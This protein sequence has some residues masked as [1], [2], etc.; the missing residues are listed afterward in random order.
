M[1][2]EQITELDFPSLF[3]YDQRDILQACKQFLNG[4]MSRADFEALVI[5]RNRTLS[6]EDEKQ[7]E[8]Y[9]SGGM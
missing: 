3:L 5:K 4:E 7:A 6:A 2:A 1:K 8:F 9:L